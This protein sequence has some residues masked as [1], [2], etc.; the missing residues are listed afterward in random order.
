MKREK[1][2]LDEIGKLRDDVD[3]LSRYLMSHDMKAECIDC[4]LP[5]EEF[6]LDMTL[7]DEQWLMI[8]REG[9]DG[10]LCANC[11]VER[12]AKLEGSIAVRAKIEIADDG[13]FVRTVKAHH[14]R[15]HGGH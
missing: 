10:L 11:I 8:H 13:W 9:Y 5:Y 15:L 6:G 3:M 2:I 7:P 4:S 12:A 14:E 1:I